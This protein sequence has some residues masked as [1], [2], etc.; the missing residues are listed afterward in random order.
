MGIWR[1]LHPRRILHAPGVISLHDVFR[2]ASIEPGLELKTIDCA[3][4]AERTPR[5]RNFKN[6]NGMMGIG[7]NHWKDFKTMTLVKIH[8]SCGDY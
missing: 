5:R 4:T 2:Q 7:I 8:V 1:T 3:T 6:L